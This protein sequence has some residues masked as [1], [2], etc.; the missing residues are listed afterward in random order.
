MNISGLSPDLPPGLPD[1]Q[2]LARLANEFFSAR[3]G[4]DITI[5]SAPESPGPGSIPHDLGGKVPLGGAAPLP[6]TLPGEAELKALLG[7]FQ[8][9]AAAPGVPGGL[10]TASTGLKRGGAGQT[11]SEPQSGPYNEYS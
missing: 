8:A 10:P 1:V 9:P 4:E 11:A 7:V 5:R 3:P 2:E 6:V